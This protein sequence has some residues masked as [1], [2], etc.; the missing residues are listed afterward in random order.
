MVL[1]MPISKINIYFFIAHP[2]TKVKGCGRGLVLFPHAP[3]KVAF[4]AG[5]DTQLR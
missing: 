2:L 3:D 1:T 4:F 5:Q